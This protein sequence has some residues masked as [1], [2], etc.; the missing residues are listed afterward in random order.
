[1]KTVI[2]VWQNTPQKCIDLFS[3]INGACYLFYLSA[4]IPFR[5]YVDIQFH[6]ISKYVESNHP[7]KQ[8]IFENKQY[9]EMIHDV[10]WYIKSS[11]SNLIFFSSTTC[12]PF[13]MTPACQTFARNLLTPKYRLTSQIQQIRSEHV[14]HVHINNPIISYPNF[15]QLFPIVYEKILPHLTS[16]TI[17][18][19]DTQEFK[20]YVKERS[21]CI[22]FDTKIGNIGFTAHDYAVEDSLLDL[23]IMTRAKYVSSFTWHDNLP[24]FL[25]IL[26]FYN[27]YVEKITH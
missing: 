18:L 14:V 6:I 12:L 24:G 3:W 2:L 21:E 7:Y 19:S 25:N 11:D 4:K 9:L 1:M 20:D 17:L 22:I 15:Q 27:V 23:Y 16:Q 5:L 13:T 10:E 26:L 8:F